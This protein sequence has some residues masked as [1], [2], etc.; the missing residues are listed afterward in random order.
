MREGNYTK[1]QK[2]KVGL[3]KPAE[4]DKW[5][6]L[7]NEHHYLGFKR[8]SGEVLKYVVEMDGEWVALLG[9]GS[10]AFKCTARDKWI[11][12]RSDQQWK[13]LKYIANN[14]RFLILPWIRIT[15]LASRILAL[16]LKRISEDWEN[17][18][19]HPL[20]MVETFVEKNRFAGTCYKAAG[21][22]RLGET[23]GYGRNAGKYYY[24][25]KKKEVFIKELS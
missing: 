21:W 10:A 2:L 13:R 15:N 9:W 11:G 5:D 7:M 20:L 23:K 19:G 1:D 6:Q 17:R 8:L 4:G 22:K 24:H 25:E 18:H 12:W 16:N 14:Q 3:L